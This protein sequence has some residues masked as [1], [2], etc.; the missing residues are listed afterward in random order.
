[1]NRH[2]KIIISFVV[3]L[4]AGGCVSSNMSDLI[5]WRDQVLARPA[6]HIKPLP[7]VKPYQAYTYQ[8]AEK[9]LRDPFEKFYKVRQDNEKKVDQNAGL[10]PEME[11]E[12][13]DRNREELEKYELDSLK[14]VGTMSQK[15]KMWALILDPDGNVTRV[16]VGN[17]MGRHIGKITN[18]YPDRIELR[19]IVQNDQGRWEERPA[20]LPLTEVK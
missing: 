20:S 5:A 4:F 17:Y 14:M 8:G 10:T 6:G 13:R 9:G 15:G 2:Y 3:L 19:E 1:M 18:I 16:K 7:E 11:H 12:L